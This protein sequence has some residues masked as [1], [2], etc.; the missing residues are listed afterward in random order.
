MRKTRQRQSKRLWVRISGE[1]SVQFRI[2]VSSE[3]R[4]LRVSELTNLPPVLQHQLHIDIQFLFFTA[5]RW[6]LYVQFDIVEVDAL[7]PYVG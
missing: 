6:N 1:Q 3:T 2:N 7:L 4:I 5:I